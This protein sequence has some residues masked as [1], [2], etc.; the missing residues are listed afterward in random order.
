ML[1]KCNSTFGYVITHCIKRRMEATAGP[2]CALP[3]EVCLWMDAKA[4]VPV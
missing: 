3:E 4:M 2:D 1:T